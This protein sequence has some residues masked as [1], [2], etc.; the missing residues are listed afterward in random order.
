[1]L[2]KGVDSAEINSL[3]SKSSIGEVKSA[4]LEASRVEIERLDA[5]RREVEGKAKLRERRITMIAALTV[6]SILFLAA[7]FGLFLARESQLSAQMLK[8]ESEQ[9]LAQALT[10]K[11]SAARQ[12]AELQKQNADLLAKLKETTDHIVNQ[13]NAT[14]QKLDEI[15]R[16][17]GIVNK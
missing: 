10:E 13:S 12:L 4:E 2:E 17:N 16:Q 7:A 15:I 8:L 3:R 9:S 11:T 1:V 14:Q 5:E 6:V